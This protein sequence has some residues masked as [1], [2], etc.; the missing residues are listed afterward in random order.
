MKSASPVSAGRSRLIVPKP[1]PQQARVQ[2]R[3]RERVA[4]GIVWGLDR[5]VRS[6]LALGDQCLQAFLAL[7]L[8]VIGD[9]QN[10]GGGPR[11]V[12]AIERL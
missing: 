1:D 8:G 12:D 9:A 10:N 2:F 11:G 5:E 7:G 6:L 3:V 4:V